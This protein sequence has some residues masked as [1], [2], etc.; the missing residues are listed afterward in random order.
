MNDGRMNDMFK[1]MDE[2]FAKVDNLTLKIDTI[3]KEHKKEINKLKKE[4]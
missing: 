3:K 4:H 2:L 1:Q